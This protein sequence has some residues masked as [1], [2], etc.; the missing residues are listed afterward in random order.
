MAGIDADPDGGFRLMPTHRSRMAH[1]SIGQITGL[2]RGLSVL[3]YVLRH[4][5]GFLA[6]RL[7]LFQIAANRRFGFPLFMKRVNVETTGACNLNCRV[8]PIGAGLN[9]PRG[10]METDVFEKSL[11][12]IVDGIHHGVF[13]SQLHLFSGGEPFTHP[14][15]KELTS[16]LLRI[17]AKYPNFPKT[18]LSTNATLLTT[19]N[20]RGIVLGGA[21]DEIIF[22]IDMGQKKEFEDMRR[23]AYFHDVLSRASNAVEMIRRAGANV[24]TRL[25]CLVPKSPK[26]D[27]A[28]DPEFL[29]LSTKVDA[30]EIRYF[31][32]W[33]GD[34]C[35]GPVSGGY[36]R[37]KNPRGLC[38]FITDNQVV[39][40]DGRITH[41]CVDISGKGAYADIRNMSLRQ[42][43]HAPIKRTML[44]WM[45]KNRRQEI[46]L[47][48][49]C[50][51]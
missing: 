23:G 36:H 13:F 26:R 5:S 14:G 31:H 20:I 49:F 42:S 41:C 3:R 29:T 10:L 38:T 40:S 9:R 11:M 33:T 46:D 7:H 1:L 27:F 4:T 8:C 17:Q 28:F 19:R 21:I 43:L 30:F 47:C 24:K 16:M 32:N 2:Q 15:L 22:S 45:G 12:D 50:K 35:L 34:A 18:A 6:A 25:V 37:S 44:E 48:R 39:L 51:I